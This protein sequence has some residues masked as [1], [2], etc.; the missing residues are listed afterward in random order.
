MVRHSALYLLGRLIP[1]AVS[2]LALALYTRLLTP[3]QYGHYALVIASV[4]IVNAVC[5]QW[6]S[7][8]LGRF[9]PAHDNH[10]Q[11]LLY[12]A[13]TGFLI[14]VAITGVLGG[15]VAWMWP[16][17][18]L[19]WFIMLAVALGWAQAW[20][21]LNLRIVNARLA[22]I[23]YGLLSSVKALLALSVGVGLFYLGLGVVGI[24]L[25]LMSGLL[26]ASFFVRRHWH[27]LSKQH[28]SSRLLKDFIVYG[29]PLTLVFIL[30][31]VLDVSDRFL[32]GWILNTKAVG[33]YAAAY[34]LTQQSLGMLMG[35]VHL[36]AFPLALRALEEK[37]VA[38]AR[39]QLRQNAF[40]LLVISV[41]A[42]AGLVVLADNIAVV[43]LGTGFREEAG[44]IIA[45]VALAI[46]V[47]GIKSYYFDYSFQLGRKMK[48]QVWAVMWAAL[49]NVGLNLWW[50]PLYGVLGAAYAT[51]GAFVVGLFVSWY[52]GRKVF[53]LPPLPK[54]SYK[55]ALASVGM[56]AS[57]WATLSWRG[58]AVLLGQ[59]L[60]GCIVY[61]ALLLVFDVGQSR[62]KLTRYVGGLKKRLQR[63]KVST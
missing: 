57:L 7:L 58:P 47:G 23:R 45:L 49:A 14:L 10:P 18:T 8:S 24:L 15:T 59:V 39:S 2:L 52:L 27:G 34:D 16:D 44:N 54:E 11:A 53:M 36:A 43:M 41:P 63:P 28:Y 22:P 5:F 60:L 1:G 33:T 46:F 29:A 38:E 17:K 62:L 21:D 51:L 6:L 13:L 25:G 56:A 40:M 48:G 12:T 4:G 35:V 9:L 55:V 50:I 19:R 3:S 26:T 20:F 32:L 30:T 61:A 31:L 42:T 37:G